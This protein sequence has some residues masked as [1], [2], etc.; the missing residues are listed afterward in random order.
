MAKQKKRKTKNMKKFLLFAALVGAAVS[1]SI[2]SQAANFSMETFTDA[3]V[4]SFALQYGTTNYATNQ[5]VTNGLGPVRTNG[6]YWFQNA[7]VFPSILQG[8]SAV[9]VGIPPYPTTGLGSTNFTTNGLINPAYLDPLLW[10]AN[11]TN[12][13]YLQWLAGGGSGYPTITNAAGQI[14]TNGG[15]PPIGPL[16]KKGARLFSDANG[17]IT[18]NALITIAAQA[19]DPTGT[20]NLFTI[21]AP[22]P[23]GTNFAFG[24]P[25]I[26]NTL[27]LNGTNLVVSSSPVP[28]SFCQGTTFAIPYS[29]AIATNGDSTFAGTNVYVSRFF[30]TGWVP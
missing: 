14:F 25:W 7:F 2:R 12:Q 20:N 30:L 23:D 22:S 17:C 29:F 8:S 1:I 16:L 28:P 13:Y 26:T 9:C 21:I 27:K 3:K 19:D 15:A 18:S 6:W 10:I 24:L 11:G 5:T 4:A